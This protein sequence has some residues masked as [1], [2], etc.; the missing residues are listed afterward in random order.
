M[1]SV[2]FDEA[3]ANYHQPVP[4]GCRRCGSTLAYDLA[5]Y[6]RDRGQFPPKA[7]TMC[8]GCGCPDPG[9][10]FGGPTMGVR[11]HKVRPA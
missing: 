4:K 1:T 6:A 7:D 11:S 9:A 5:A 2:S 3:F 8:A 10:R